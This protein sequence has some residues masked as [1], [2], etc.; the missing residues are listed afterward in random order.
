MAR[1]LVVGGGC[2]ALDLTRELRAEGHAIRAVTRS[3]ERRS[4]IEATG[5]ECVIADPDVVGSLRY[6]LDNVTL[7]LWLLGTATGDNVADLHGSRLAMM[8]ERT[9][10]TTARGVVYEAAGTVAPAVLA[11]GRALVERVTAY[12]EIPLRVLEADPADRPAWVRAAR[13]AV[14]AL[15][16][17]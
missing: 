2:R 13:G 10:D 1:L 9:I 14:D 5:A 15:L 6:A 4:A 7:V 11:D 8:L 17:A 16:A 3:E 12:N